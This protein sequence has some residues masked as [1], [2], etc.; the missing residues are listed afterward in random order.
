MRRK[1]FE[2]K[3]AHG[4]LISCFSQAIKQ[5]LRWQH[6]CLRF[7]F[8]WIDDDDV[9]GFD[10]NDTDAYQR[11]SKFSLMRGRYFFFTSC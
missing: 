10:G 9:E 5:S 8:S 3:L 1:S 11:K 4:Q 7:L 6:L 2:I